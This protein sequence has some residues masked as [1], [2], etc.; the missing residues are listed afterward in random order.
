MTS[1]GA[2]RSGDRLVHIDALRGFALLGILAVN[3]ALFSSGYAFTGIADPNFSSF[4]DNAVEWAVYLLFTMKFYL[5]F[6]FL[7]GY[8]FTL[9]LDSAQRNGRP[10]KP[11]FLRRLAALFVLG[12]A[13]AVL[14]FPGDILSTYAILGLILLAVRNIRPRTAIVLA[15]VLTVGTTA[16]VVLV[17]LS[18]AVTADP[19]AALVEG[20]RATE[21]L[22]GAPSEVIAEHV[23]TL[24][25]ILGTLAV[26][27]PL[28]FTSFLIGLAV[29]KIKA[30]GDLGRHERVLRML[31]WVGLPVGL[32]GSLVFASFGGTHNTL[33]TAVG[34]ATAPLLTAAYVAT[35]LRVFS[36]PRAWVLTEFLAAGG[37]LA[38]TNYLLQSLVCALIF[39]GLGAGVIGQMSPGVVL[40]MTFAVFFAQIILSYIWLR[41]FRYGPVEWLLRAV[42]YAT[43]RPRSA[44]RL[45]SAA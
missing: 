39:T 31:Q 13:H 23:R 36:S 22:R 21:A 3:M 4:T 25:W 8:S 12:V 19:A 14:L 43:W 1:S 34:Y 26:Q 6:S 10:F 45:P 30:L 2:A 28:A 32:S 42:T 27:G 40:L 16:I 11:A 44:R 35:M 37:R 5:L 29:G 17:G 18:G 15:G 24:P 41:L 9:Q 38:L 33:A 20:Q 7:F